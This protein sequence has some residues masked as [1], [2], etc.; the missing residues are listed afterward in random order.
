MTK[1]LQRYADEWQKNAEADALWVILTDSRFYG[2]KWDV[3]AFFATGYEEIDRVFSFMEKTSVKIPSDTFLDFGCGVGRVS[4][5]LREKFRSGYGVDISKK[6]IEHARNYVQG[7][8]F[9]ANQ[10][11]SLDRFPDNSIDFVYSHIVLQHI[12]NEYQKGYIDE[13]LRILAPGGL[14]VFQIPVRLIHPEEIKP[15]AFYRFKQSIK[16]TFPFLVSLKRWIIPPKNFH[17]DFKYEMHP[18]PDDIVR[19]ICKIRKCNIE[20]SPATNSCDPDHNGKVEFYNLVEHER[21]LEQSDESNLYLSCMYFVR[22]P[23]NLDG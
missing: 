6:M 18:L 20:A 19:R 8:E 23:E 16:R 14:A 7:V 1:S 5:A 2:K 15:G 22:K 9:I 11:N 10:T 4:K 13:F 17:F 3:E 21:V 12:P